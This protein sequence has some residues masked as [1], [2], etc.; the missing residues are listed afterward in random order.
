MKR[1]F[2]LFLL[3][4][5]ASS[6]PARA[7]VANGS[8]TAASSSCLT[9]NCVAVQV[10][11]DS[12]SA[13]ISIP[14]TA[15]F[16][17]TIQFEAVAIDGTVSALNCT[18]P[19]STT[20]VTSTTTVGQ[21]KCDVASQGV[22][23]ARCSA[24]TSGTAPVTINATKG[25]STAILAGGGGGGGGSPTGAAGGDLTGTYPNP[26]VGQINGAAVPASAKLLGSNA[27]S[28]AIAAALLNTHLYVGNASNLPVD[29]ALSGDCTMA[30]TGA[31]TCTKTA[32]TAFATSATTDTTNA[33]NISTGTLA[34]PR[35]PTA[36][37][38]GSVGSAGL[39]G[40]GCMSI[41][42]TGVISSTCLT[43]SGISGLTSTQIPIAGSAT[44]LTSSV[45]AP[46]GAIVGT[47]DTQTLTNKSIASTEIT[48]LA[49]SAT[50]DTTNA[51]N[52]S[53]GVLPSARLTAGNM[54]AA[55]NCPVSSGSA[56]AYVCVTPAG[57]TP[58]DGAFYNVQFDVANTGSATLS[59]NGTV[60]TITKQG[61]GTNLV[62]ND[63]IVGMD[64]PVQYDGSNYQLWCPVANAP[65]GGGSG[66]GAVGYSGLP[67]VSATVYVPLQGD[68]VG[69]TT[70]ANVGWP[71]PSA[72]PISNM[73][74]YS[75]SVPGTGNTLVFTLMDGSTAESITCTITAAA[76]SC[77]DTTHSFTPAAG[78]LL[79]WRIAPTG[80]VVITPNIQIGASWATPQAGG[81]SGLTSGQ[82]PIAGSSTSA[83]SSKPLNGTDANIQTG[84]TVAAS[85]PVGCT[86]ANSGFTTTGCMGYGII[87]GGVASFTTSTNTFNIW[88]AGGST[89]GFAAAA[90]IAPRAMTLTGMYA[91][92]STSQT[93]TG[94]TLT[95][96]SCTPSS[97][98]CTPSSTAI[99]CTAA[100]NSSTAFGCNITGQSVALNAGDVYIMAGT[101]NGTAV[102]STVITWGV[103]YK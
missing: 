11:A 10:N 90:S 79:T 7:Q 44:T 76:N 3:L 99:T 14:S 80:T 89:A 51:A 8:I 71:A 31:I 35:L 73:Y 86:D 66:G 30:N 101:L 37:P 81:L 6:P 16:S 48:G 1:L 93:T 19:N 50:T 55:F 4:L 28:Q 94:Y 56:T 103:T 102:S 46:V 43:S 100:V 2:W 34:V 36:I 61:G 75:S 68:T 87:N 26:G 77:N 27:S 40:T 67:A 29:V 97:G 54:S 5:V 25:V 82:V 69:S 24:F 21:W 33:S 64:C 88:R 32:G 13:V 91:F 83:T 22:V 98:T 9:T 74:A 85:A 42:S 58:V 92:F 63:I 23:R 72:S 49:A 96:Q 59:V 84:G 39:S 60:G 53:S 20:A 70:I 15:T 65:S 62:A 41:A 78:D 12:S 57:V 52:I 45:A 47:T 17:A 18:A 95:V 38:I